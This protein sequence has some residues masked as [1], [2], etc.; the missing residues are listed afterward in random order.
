MTRTLHALWMVPGAALAAL[1]TWA[2][3]TW[4]P[5][6]PG[7]PFFVC[8]LFRLT[9]LYCP[10]CGGTRMAHALVHFDLPGALAMNVLPFIAAPLL[11]VLFLRL[12]TTLSPRLE[13]L[14]RFVAEPWFWVALVGG[15]T[16]LRNLPWAPFN[17]LAP[18]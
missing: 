10:G 12:N 17:W 11:G 2:L 14:T 6:Q 1:A 4:D 3:R 13:R 5:N 8:T 16:V 7:N 9:G 15:F 18:G